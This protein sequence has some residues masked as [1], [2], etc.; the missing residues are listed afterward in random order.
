MHPITL[1]TSDAFGVSSAVGL[2]IKCSFF[3][4]KVYLIYTAAFVAD[5]IH[6][7]QICVYLTIDCIYDTHLISIAIRRWI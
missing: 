1:Y 4:V 6:F 5:N 2:S 3:G 7:C